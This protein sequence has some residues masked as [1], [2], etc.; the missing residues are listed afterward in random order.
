MRKAN[1]SVQTLFYIMMAIFMVAII[2]YGIEKIF[3]TQEMLEDSELT[4]I[5]Q[6]IVSTLEYCDDPLNSGKRIIE[7]QNPKVN[8]VCILSGTKEEVEDFFTFE[9]LEEYND[10][11]EDEIEENA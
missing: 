4:F 8:S 9:N 5:K 6:E 10:I 1:I 7:I 2:I 3:D 11:V